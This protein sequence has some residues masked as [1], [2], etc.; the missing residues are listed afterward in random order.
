LRKVKRTLH[1]RGKTL[2]EF[3]AYAFLTLFSLKCS[4][5]DLDKPSHAYSK[6]QLGIYTENGGKKLVFCLECSPQT[7]KEIKCG[8]CNKTKDKAEFANS[9]FSKGPGE[10]VRVLAVCR[11]Q[12]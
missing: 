9:Q 8:G 4:D 2:Y 1:L 10:A 7:V 3:Y 12:S 11:V 5:C 6:R